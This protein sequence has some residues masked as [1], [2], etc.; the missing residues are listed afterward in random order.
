[1]GEEEAA[2]GSALVEQA[3]PSLGRLSAKNQPKPGT[4][5]HNCVPSTQKAEVGG[6][7]VEAWTPPQRIKI[8]A[9]QG[10]TPR[11]IPKLRRQ[12]LEDC[13]K[14]ESSLDTH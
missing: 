1:M 4:V 11:K 9:R 13:H 7:K 3:V 2:A 6:Q 14:F 12:R 5:T 8:K 10:G